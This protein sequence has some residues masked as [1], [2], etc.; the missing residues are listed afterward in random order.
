MLIFIVSV[1][2]MIVMRSNKRIRYSIF[3]N[4]SDRRLQVAKTADNDIQ[5]VYVGVNQ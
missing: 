2:D 4:P 5:S 3:H 1:D